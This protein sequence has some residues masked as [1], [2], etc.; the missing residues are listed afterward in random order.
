[1]KIRTK[2]HICLAVSLVCFLAVLGAVGSIEHGGMSIGKGALVAL[3]GLLVGSAAAYK[4]G[5]IK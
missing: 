2:R 4:G 3:V 1:M 5:Y